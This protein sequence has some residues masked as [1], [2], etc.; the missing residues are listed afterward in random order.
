MDLSTGGDLKSIR[1]M[2]LDLC[3]VPVGTVPIYEAA[4]KARVSY[5]GVL[6]MKEEDLFTVIE[7]HAAEG[8]DF[9]TVHCGLTMAALDCLRSEGR[10]M[11]LVSRGGAILAGWMLEN[12]K[13]NPLYENFDRLLEIA[14]RHDVTLSLGDGMRPGCIEDATDRAQI[15]NC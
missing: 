15:Q 7:E 6:K 4:A 5:G 9:I 10:I 13:E 1:S 12:E 2:V 14:A 11:G 3:P 8:V